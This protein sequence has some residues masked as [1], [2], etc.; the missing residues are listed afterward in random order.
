MK[1]LVTTVCLTSVAAFGPAV[2]AQEN[3]PGAASITRPGKHAERNWAKTCESKILYADKPPIGDFGPRPNTQVQVV[4][5]GPV[6]HDYRS[7]PSGPWTGTYESPNCKSNSIRK[8]VITDGGG[9]S[10][11]VQAWLALDPVTGPPTD[12]DDPIETTA[13]AF[14]D[15][16]TTSANDTIVVPFDKARFKPLFTIT[17]DKPPISAGMQQLRYVTYTCLLHGY[18]G[19]SY[20]TGRLERRNNQSLTIPK[21]PF[22]VPHSHKPI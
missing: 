17:R 21:A 1:Q 9:G 7:A 20:L 10:L 16:S 12:L 19:N 14:R 4:D 6:V 5:D 8:L 2:H 18:H 15:S 11:K 13:S 22:I 3:G